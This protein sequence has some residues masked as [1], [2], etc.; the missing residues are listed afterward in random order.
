M[1]SSL[2]GLAPFASNTQRRDL[3][4]VKSSAAPVD[5]HAP[6]ERDCSCASLETTPHHKSRVMNE[7]LPRY[8]EQLAFE[9]AL[10]GLGLFDLSGHGPSAEEFGQAL[11]QARWAVRDFGLER[12]MDI[13][14]LDARCGRFFTYRQLIECGET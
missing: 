9:E 1:A 4:Q 8:A 2:N 14:E 3:L 10:E 6:P 5:K 7:E 13:P 11:S 12:A